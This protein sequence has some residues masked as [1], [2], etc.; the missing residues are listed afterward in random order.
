MYLLAKVAF[1]QVFSPYHGNPFMVRLCARWILGDAALDRNDCVCVAYSETCGAEETDI[2]EERIDEM[3]QKEE[4][5]L[6]GLHVGASLLDV[7]DLVIAC[8]ACKL[9]AV[10][11]IDDLGSSHGFSMMGLIFSADQTQTFR[12]SKMLGYRFDVDNSALTEAGRRHVSIE[13]MRTEN[14][15][16][17]N[18]LGTTIGA[19]SELQQC[20]AGPRR[21][22]LKGPSAWV[23]S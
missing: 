4:E 8:V 1:I 16:N 9:S 19:G 18:E 14:A 17:A 12:C 3:T 7:R 23:R 22:A 2:G 10:C 6:K 13:W 21:S 5:K 15:V 20:C 11:S